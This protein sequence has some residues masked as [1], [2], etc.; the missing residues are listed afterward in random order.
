[1]AYKN[2]FGTR[3][4]NHIVIEMDGRAVGLI[5]NLRGS[6]DYGLEPVSGIGSI[7]VQ[8]YVPTVARHQVSCGLVALRRHE[9]GALDFIPTSGDG[10][11][12]NEDIENDGNETGA[13]DGMIFDIVVYDRNDAATAAQTDNA[14]TTV[15]ESAPAS[16]AHNSAAVPLKKY[17]GCSY[18]SGDFSIDAHR[19]V[20]RNATFMALDVSGAL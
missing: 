2:P 12:G 3:T 14:E 4:G 16:R 17:I 18:A 11:T 1:M 7:Q 5:Q 8:E 6:D 9:L 20:I 10:R 15:N 13:L 19:I